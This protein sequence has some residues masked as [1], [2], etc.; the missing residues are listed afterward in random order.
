MA[1]TKSNKQW[2]RA[3]ILMALAVALIDY[4]VNHR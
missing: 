3:I 1:L 2:I 4:L